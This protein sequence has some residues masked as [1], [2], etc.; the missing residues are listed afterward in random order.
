MLLLCIKFPTVVFECAINYASA[1][2]LVKMILKMIRI[3]AVNK[4][5]ESINIH[6][7]N[8]LLLMYIIDSGL[9]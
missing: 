5:I 4:L 2:V 8:C 3:R 1:N 6:Y 7:L 9:A